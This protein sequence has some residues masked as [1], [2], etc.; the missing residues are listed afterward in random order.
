MLS[1]TDQSGHNVITTSNPHRPKPLTSLMATLTSKPG[2]TAGSSTPDTT[3]AG[4]FAEALKL[5][6]RDADAVE[7]A[8]V[9]PFEELSRPPEAPVL[10][11][12]NEMPASDDAYR[13]RVLVVDD[14]ASIRTLL[15]SLLAK[16][17]HEVFAANNG[18]QAFEMALDLRPQLMVVDWV[19]PEMDG[20]E[21]TRALRQT[22]IGR[23]IYILILTSLEDE[24]RLIEAFES[25]VDDFMVKPVKPRVLG[26]RLRAG[27]RVVRLQQE[28]ERDREEIRRFAAELAVTNRRLQEVALT[29]SLTGFPNRRYA[30]ERFVQEW[31]ATTRSKRPLSCM[32][33]DLDAFKIV[34]D[35]YGHDVGDIVLKQVAAALKSGLRTQDVVS[36]IGGDE[37][38]VICPDTPLDA[39]L[40]CGERVRRAVEL[41][42]IV[43]GG[44]HF[45]GSI[46]V[47]VATREVGM[48]DYHALIKVA[49]RGAYLAKERGKNC[50]ATVQTDV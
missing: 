32:V 44:M 10:D 12:S 9:P 28:I 11:E 47:G 23:G 42:Q 33:I 30:M 41:Q 20:I 34:N 17:G 16:S 7:A 43:A 14:D 27:L 13:M 21:L 3:A 46:S 38:L 1:R 49:D 8:S 19:M 26:A 15:C 40:M 18:Q 29:D 39:A 22:K 37:F 25:G 31:G 6:M 36:R 2:A 5:Q 24:D 4:L 48:A 50:V 35:T 45:K